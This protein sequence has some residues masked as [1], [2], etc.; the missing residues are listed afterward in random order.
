MIKFKG[1]SLL[2]RYL[3]LKPI[4]REYKVYCLADAL[5]RCLYNF[6]I[7]TGKQENK[8]ETLDEAVVLHLISSLSLVKHQL[9]FDNFSTTFPLLLQLEKKKIGT[10]GTI[11]TNRK[12]FLETLR[13]KDK[14]ERSDY[15]CCLQPNLSGQMARQ[16]INLYCR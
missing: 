5:I 12:L 2:K 3:P 11:R 15:K 14:L 1:R 7:Y 4:K 16:K 6:D 10:T 9:F 13:H 8:Q